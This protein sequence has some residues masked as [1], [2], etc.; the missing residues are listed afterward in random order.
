M[1][2]RGRTVLAFV[3][4]A[5]FASSLLTLTIVDPSI[6]FARSAKVSAVPADRSGLKPEDLEKISTVYELIRSKYLNEVD[7]DKVMDGAIHG[8]LSALGDPF[9]TYMDKD[10]AQHFSDSLNST[11]Q[12]IGA[13]VTM[14]DGK[15][16]V[17]S[18]IKGSPAE[19]A[20]I[21]ANDIIL[22]INGEKLDG[23][24]LNQAVMKIRGPKG[25]QAK[26]EIL[27]PGA[28]E[29]TQIIVIRDDIPQETVYAKM[30]E[31]QIGLIEI[32]QF[33]TKTEERFLEELE[34]LENQGMKG[35]IIDVRNNPGGILPAVVHMAEPFMPK[36]KTIVYIEDR[37]GRRQPTVSQGGEKPY[38]IAVLVNG[39]SASASEILAAALQ[40]VAGSYVIGENSFGKGTVQLT[41]SQELGDGS[42]VKM[43]VYKWLTPNGNWIN[44]KG[45]TPDIRVEQ[46]EYFRVAP[47]SRNTTLKPDMTGEDVKNLQI[48]LSGLGL[49]PQRKDGYF[50]ERTALSVKEFQ[51]KHGLPATGEV[52]KATA[53]R[54]EEEIIKKIR[55]P[56]NDRQLQTAIQHIQKEIGKSGK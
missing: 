47:L 3:L 33:S 28:T 5:M 12:G 32:R 53:D 9:T 45:I 48:M 41:F 56:K 36:G 24:T 35:L 26:L 20:G 46:P 22:S 50:N 19:K 38:P 16:V 10:E 15:V 30:L 42:N 14:V 29:P 1:V 31:G 54:L 44:E 11:F 51:T 49:D 25:T 21:H 17:V 7:H 6:F 2:F 27:R 13:E 43:T 18:P 52:D 55:D 4:L 8:M 40:E 34:S 39:G 37:E 23:L